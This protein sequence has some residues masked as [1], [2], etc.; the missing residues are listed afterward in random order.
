MSLP[1]TAVAALAGSESEGAGELAP[2]RATLI[3]ARHL[4]SRR[5][6]SKACLRGRARAVG[7]IAERGYDIR[8]GVIAHR[9]RQIVGCGAI[10]GQAIEIIALIIGINRLKLRRP[11]Y[12]VAERKSQLS[13]RLTES[14]IADDRYLDMRLHAVGHQFAG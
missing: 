2:G 7:Q 14:A 10:D 9:N 5:I 13:D 1:S 3:K 4:E 12:L 11:Q 8:I 6:R